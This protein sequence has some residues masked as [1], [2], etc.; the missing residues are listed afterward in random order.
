MVNHCNLKI[1]YHQ[2]EA[3]GHIVLDGD[4][5]IISRKLIDKQFNEIFDKVN[6]LEVNLDL[7]DYID[8]S[9]LAALFSI[10]RSMLKSNKP[11]VISGAN[12]RIK[13]LFKITNFEEYLEEFPVDN[14]DN[15]K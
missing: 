15:T 11:L 14:K 5:D 4:L 2:E 7:V 12:S 8:S 10:A 1:T 13:N 6:R 9:G 3:T